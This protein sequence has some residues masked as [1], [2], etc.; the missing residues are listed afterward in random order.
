MTDDELSDQNVALC[1]LDAFHK[2]P[3]RCKPFRR[4]S[5]RPEWTVFAAFVLSRPHASTSC[6]EYFTVSIGCV[7]C[8]LLKLEKDCD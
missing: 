6:R 2:L 7:C 3:K 8:A 5:G 4:D 1:A